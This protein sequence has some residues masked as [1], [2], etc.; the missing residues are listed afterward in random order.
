ME[1]QK[2]L[3]TTREHTLKWM[4][5]RKRNTRNYS[6][7]SGDMVLSCYILSPHRHT[8]PSFQ[9]LNLEKGQH[10]RPYDLRLDETSYK[11]LMNRIDMSAQEYISTERY[12]EMS[13]C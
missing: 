3:G 10:A 4:N 7:E 5:F 2:T 8:L 12:M 1:P 9:L 6:L 13:D 11:K